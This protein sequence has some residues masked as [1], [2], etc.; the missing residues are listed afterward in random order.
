MILH[1]FSRSCNGVCIRFDVVVMPGMIWLYIGDEDMRFD[2]LSFAAA[3]QGQKIPSSS[4]LMK[5]AEEDRGPTQVAFIF[6]CCFFDTTFIVSGEVMAKRICMRTGLR[7]F[8]SCNINSAPPPLVCR[9]IA[10]S[11]IFGS[12]RSVPARGRRSSGS[13]SIKRS[14]HNM[15]S[16]RMQTRTDKLSEW[17]R[18][19][20]FLFF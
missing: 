15:K 6:R 8:C 1:E 12:K 14:W 13:R 18:M 11:S 3:N 20:L 2:A 9:K 7:V 19:S 17:F 10:R 4:C 5:G 16:F